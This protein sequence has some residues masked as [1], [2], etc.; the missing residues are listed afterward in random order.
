M[1]AVNLYNRK[2]VRDLL[3]RTTELVDGELVPVSYATED[4][5]PLLPSIGI[6]WEF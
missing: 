3:P 1:G 6:N 4:W 2:N 5:F